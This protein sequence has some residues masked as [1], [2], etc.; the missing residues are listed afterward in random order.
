MALWQYQHCISPFD[1]FQCFLFLTIIHANCYVLE[2]LQTYVCLNTIIHVGCICSVPYSCMQM[3]HHAMLSEGEQE[4]ATRLASED[5]QATHVSHAP[6][7]ATASSSRGIPY[8][9]DSSYTPQV[10]PL[11]LILMALHLQSPLQASV[12]VI[13]ALLTS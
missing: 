11:H 4:E 1:H 6:S 10:G 5:R 9:A 2:T 8:A 3:T 13:T 7:Q 12:Q